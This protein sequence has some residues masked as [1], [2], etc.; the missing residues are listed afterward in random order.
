MN[1]VTLAG[2]K[3]LLLAI[4]KNI[5]KTKRAEV[6]I[7]PPFVYLSNLVGAFTFAK[8]FGGLA[9]GSQDCFWEK[10]G[11]FTG[12]VS[13]EMLSNVG[14]KYVIA[15]HSERRRYFHETD[16]VVNKKAKAAIGAGLRII[17]CVGET[18]K[19]RKTGKTGEVLRRQLRAGLKEITP[20][21]ALNIIVVYEPVWA[22]GTGMAC[23]P[24]EAA[25]ARLRIKKMIL[26]KFGKKMSESLPVLY[27]GSVNSK[28]AAP[29]VKEAGFN[30]LLVGGASLIG[31]EFVKIID[32]VN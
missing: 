29:Y 28:N 12:E 21:Q 11:A 3:R 27:G 32:A 15:G 18:L 7:C 22:I 4:D 9:F 20:G 17:L 30:G 31:K 19:E 5:R 24:D 25:H 13:P 16:D 6:I 26:V 8:G 1:P 23:A 2:A 14:C 10:K